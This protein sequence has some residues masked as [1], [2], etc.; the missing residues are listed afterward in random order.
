MWRPWVSRTRTR[1]YP[2]SLPRINPAR[3]QL[4]PEAVAA[5]GETGE[6]TGE[7][8]ER[9]IAVSPEPPEAADKT[10]TNPTR[11]ARA[12][13]R[14]RD[15]PPHLQNLVVNAIM[16]METRLGTVWSQPPVPGLIGVSQGIEDLTN[17]TGKIKI[18]FNT[19]R[20]FQ[21]LAPSKYI[22]TIKYA[23][24]QTQKI[25]YFRQPMSGSVQ[26]LKLDWLGTS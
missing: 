18:I 19:T 2:P 10:P 25:I 20:C 17:L 7:A 11:T 6:V 26:R 23:Q 8:G 12:G 22:K 4:S 3:L 24:K 16:F 13:I 1:P 15:T 9:T 14:E 21:A 5:V